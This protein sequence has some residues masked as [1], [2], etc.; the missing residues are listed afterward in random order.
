MPQLTGSPVDTTGRDTSTETTNDHIS[1]LSADWPVYSPF[2]R[3]YFARGFAEG[4][5]TG[6][7]EGREEG[8]AAGLAAALMT[9]LDARR[10]DVPDDLRARISACTDPAQ[11][12]TWL[13]R[14]PTAATIDDLFTMTGQ[15]SARLG[16]DHGA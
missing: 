5:A 12:H 7:A 14:V 10:I 1:L 11:L 4:F 3:E 13:T 8:R 2:A 9:A 16:G 15:P 6:L